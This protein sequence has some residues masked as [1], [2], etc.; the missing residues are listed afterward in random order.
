MKRAGTK[1]RAHAVWL[2]VVLHALVLVVA[3]FLVLQQITV[4]PEYVT[5][6]IVRPGEQPVSAPLAERQPTAAKRPIE[7]RSITR[8]TVQLPPPADVPVLSPDEPVALNELELIDR[9]FFGDSLYTIIKANPNL[10]PAVLRQM[11]VEN[12]P[13]TDSLETLRK[14]LAEAMLPYINMSEPERQAR[15]HMKLF[16]TPTNP[17]RP[18]P[19]PGNIPIS[20]ILILLIQLLK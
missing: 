20:D 15:F 13:A 19:I 11:L 1:Y 16:G 2:S 4:A 7:R 6:E 3:R 14:Q 12:V 8:P 18:G 5:V 10:R 9:A 17:M